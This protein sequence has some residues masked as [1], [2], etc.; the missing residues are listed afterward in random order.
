MSSVKTTLKKTCRMFTT[1]YGVFCF[2]TLFSLISI[3]GFPAGY[4][5]SFAFEHSPSLSM[6]TLQTLWDPAAWVKPHS[7][8]L[9]ALSGTCDSVNVVKLIF[10]A[11]NVWC[12]PIPYNT[13]RIAPIFDESCEMHLTLNKFSKLVR[14]KWVVL[15]WLGIEPN[16][17]RFRI[18]ILVR[19]RS[20]ANSRVW[21]YQTSIL[22]PLRG[23]TFLRPF[24]SCRKNLVA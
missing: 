14:P 8:A 2:Y 21:T 6:G 15:L 3:Q 1:F 18:L 5:N 23:S 10:N 20:E 9:L 4:P 22:P 16:Q 17:S 24:K 11:F 13:K 19:H 12:F 7:I